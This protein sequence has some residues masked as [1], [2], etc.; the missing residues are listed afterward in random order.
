[1]FTKKNPITPELRYLTQ[2]GSVD[3]IWQGRRFPLGVIGMAA[4]LEGIPGGTVIDGELA[5]LGPDGRPE[6]NPY[7][8]MNSK[9]QPTLLKGN[10]SFWFCSN[11]LASG[12]FPCR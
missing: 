8:W 6:F 2:N 5:A 11:N 10:G 12:L 7:I 9:K 4:A 3:A 1:V